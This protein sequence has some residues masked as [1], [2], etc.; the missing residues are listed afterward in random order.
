MM[1]E[2][3]REGGREAVGS[4]APE[5]SGT[6]GGWNSP[7]VYGKT[8]GRASRTAPGTA[9]CL[10]DG[11][12]R[13]TGILDYRRKGWVCPCCGTAILIS[14]HVSNP[15]SLSRPLLPPPPGGLP[16]SAPDPSEVIATHLHL[17]GLDLQLPFERFL[18]VH[19]R[20]GPRALLKAAKSHP[21]GARTRLG[22]D[23]AR[24]GTSASTP[25]SLPP[26]AAQPWG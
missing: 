18:A 1:R 22:G 23:T 13:I 5:L 10:P 19:L 14:T 17:A 16:P 9:S 6:E 4:G 15:A 3:G 2:G 7:R 8:R 24:T 20:R 25:P 12:T 26:A 21:G 11:G